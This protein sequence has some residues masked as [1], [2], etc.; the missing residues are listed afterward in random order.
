MPLNIMHST[1]S[2]ELMK[3]RHA[4]QTHAVDYRMRVRALRSEYNPVGM[5][6]P[7][8]HNTGKQRHAHL[9]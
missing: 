2:H 7:V 4:M 1:G 5:T 6:S 8:A 3:M 9:P